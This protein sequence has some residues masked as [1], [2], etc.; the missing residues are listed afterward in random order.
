MFGLEEE[1]NDGLFIKGVKL[2]WSW[3]ELVGLW[4]VCVDSDIVGMEMGFR[5]DVLES[6]SCG[7]GLFVKYCGIWFK[8]K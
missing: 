2:W 1:F 3:C 6:R 4:W 7:F 8:L 5:V